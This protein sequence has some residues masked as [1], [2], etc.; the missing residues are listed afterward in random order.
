MALPGCLDRLIGKVAQRLEQG[1]RTL[2]ITVVRIQGQQG[3]NLLQSAGIVALPQ[4]NCREDV[5][6]MPSC[7]RLGP[8]RKDLSELLFTCLR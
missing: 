2:G 1:Q 4:R 7:G 3:I 6:D 8:S 5:M